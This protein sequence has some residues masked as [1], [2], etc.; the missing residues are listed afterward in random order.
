MGVSPRQG[1]VRRNDVD[2]FNWDDDHNYIPAG[3]G[4][5]H[6]PSPSLIHSTDGVE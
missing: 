3:A 1:G 5:Y 2:N 6:P 4:H